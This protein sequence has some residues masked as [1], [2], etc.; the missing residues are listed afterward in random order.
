M[1]EPA[2]IAYC[3]D[4]LCAG[5]AQRQT[6]EL[7]TRLDRRRFTPS[8]LVVH[9]QREGQ[10]LHFAGDLRQAGVEVVDLDLR[11]RPLELPRC[12]LWVA[13]AVRARRPALLHSISLHSNH[14][15]RLGRWLLPRRM[16]LLA[17]IRTEYSARQ[18][19]YE[20]VE[21]RFAD[22][23]VTNSPDVARKLKDLC[24][25]P[26]GRLHVIPNGLNLGRFSRNPDTG[27]RARLA[28]GASRVVAMLAR[29]TVQKSPNLLAE[30]VGRL[31]RTGRLPADVRFWVVGE[32]ENDGMQAKFDAALAQAGVADQF[33]QLPQTPQPEPFY[34]AADFTVLPSLWEGLPNAAIESFAA[35][36]PV[37]L[38][39]AANAAGVVTEGRTGW[40]CRTNDVPHLADR[41]GE[42]LALPD[43]A[44][45][46][47]AGP[48]RARAAD[49]SMERMVA[50][51]EELYDGL[52]GRAPAG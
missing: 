39:E 14:L 44:L 25:V 41:L 40:V 17:A 22:G 38:S 8:V 49:F 21:Q 16:R 28:P 19:F 10:S 29:I 20:R 33:L 51:Y 50:R 36:K 4:T 1:P 37:L 13:R 32:R 7:V 12:F 34:H 18:Y 31:K 26:S 9:S 5:G 46:E 2:A 6:V 27:L 45:A 42:V 47:M 15:T 30:A 43:A 23:I 35:G 3:I 24:H 48:C 52:L 11:W